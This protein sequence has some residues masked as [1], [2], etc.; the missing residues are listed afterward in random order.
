M[1]GPTERM[2]AHPVCTSAT[3]LGAWERG[4]IEN[5]TVWRS[6][7]LT[8]PLRD[9]FVNRE[10]LEFYET[11]EIVQIVE[12][13]VLVFVLALFTDVGDLEPALMGVDLL[14]HG[15]GL[16]GLVHGLV[17]LG[18]SEDLIIVPIFLHVLGAGL[19]GQLG[20]QA[21]LVYQPHQVNF[22]L[23]VLILS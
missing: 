23:L 6:G 22:H 5:T 16:A 1:A 11:E 4:T 8:A 20:G 19:Q 10:H 7:M 15:P 14:L 3:A 13:V 17:V 2:T 18:R 9:R 12:V 21:R